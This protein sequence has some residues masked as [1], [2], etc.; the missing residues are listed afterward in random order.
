[1]DW[2][3][4]GDKDSVSEEMKEQMTWAVGQKAVLLDRIDKAHPAAD[5]GE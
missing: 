1:M 4:K 5:I 3:H 2:P